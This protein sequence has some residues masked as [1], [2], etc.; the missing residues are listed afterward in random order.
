MSTLSIPS[1][2]PL[3]TLNCTSC[4]STFIR[5]TA[6]YNEYLE[7][8]SRDACLANA[9]YRIKGSEWGQCNNCGGRLSPSQLP[10]E[11][12]NDLL[13]NCILLDEG[14]NIQWTG[15]TRAHALREQ[16]LITQLHDYAWFEP[17]IPIL[18][19]CLN[20]LWNADMNGLS[21]RVLAEFL[22]EV[23]YE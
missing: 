1:T 11:A 18:Q 3:C 4:T 7:E 5:N 14:A 6:A 8:E 21:I 20:T 2:H 16:S 15:E 22:E 9:A 19:A 13:Q 23:M 10:E 17:T 12:A